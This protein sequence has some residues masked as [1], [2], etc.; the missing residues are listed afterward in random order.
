MPL[1]RSMLP[2]FLIGEKAFLNK[3]SHIRPCKYIAE[4]TSIEK[5]NANVSDFGKFSEFLKQFRYSGIGE[6]DEDHAVQWL[7]N[8]QFEGPDPL[9][10]D[11]S[12]EDNCEHYSNFEQIATA[13]GFTAATWNQGPEYSE[14]CCRHTA[15]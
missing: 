13:L 14:E 2:N 7:M 12:W 4:P 9:P 10:K 8:R 5:E 1:C 6:I 15:W 3:Q 11:S